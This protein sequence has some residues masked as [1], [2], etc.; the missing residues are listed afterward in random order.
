MWLGGI[1]EMR[2]QGLNL[3]ST[4]ESAS[5]HGSVLMQPAMNVVQ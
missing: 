4:Q 1:N 5:H 2:S 3:P